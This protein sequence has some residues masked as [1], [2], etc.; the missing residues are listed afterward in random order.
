MCCCHE[1]YVEKYDS[2]TVINPLPRDCNRLRTLVDVVE[3]SD[4]AVIACSYELSV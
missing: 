3:I 1:E 2:E 4:S